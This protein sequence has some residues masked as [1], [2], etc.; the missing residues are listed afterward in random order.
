MFCA[1]RLDTVGSLLCIA[2]GNGLH[3]WVNI[4]CAAAGGASSCVINTGDVGVLT[5]GNMAT[6]TIRHATISRS[7]S[8]SSN[9][10][11]SILGGRVLLPSVGLFAVCSTLGGVNFYCTFGAGSRLEVSLILTNLFASAIS[12]NISVRRLSALI[13]VL[14]MFVGM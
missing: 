11:S 10:T 3:G 2:R 4:G 1:G 8:S 6:A 5:T 12:W 9:G 13:V 14:V 7:C